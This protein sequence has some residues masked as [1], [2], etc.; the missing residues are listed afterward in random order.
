MA[1]SP[2]L[3]QRGF[4]LAELLTVIMIVIILMAILFPVIFKAKEKAKETVCLS[5]LHQEYLAV[6]LYEGDW[7]ALPRFSSRNAWWMKTYFGGARL[8]C[9]QSNAGNDYEIICGLFTHASTERMRHLNELISDCRDKRGPS[10]PYVIDLNHLLET[11]EYRGPGKAVFM[12][13]ADGSASR[14]PWHGGP[15]L[16][17]SD[18]EQWPCNALGYELEPS[19][20]Y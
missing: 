17:D 13:R 9:P 12:V 6:K 11:Q 20:S 19:Y 5:N 14:I 4:T 10:F 1:V 18:W 8:A 2:S 15:Y 3:R 16:G 7:D